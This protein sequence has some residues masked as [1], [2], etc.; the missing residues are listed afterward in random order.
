MIL[1]YCIARSSKDYLQPPNPAKAT[2][3]LGQKLPDAMPALNDR[4]QPEA[5]TAAG[6][7]SN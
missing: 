3:A 4:N 2:A 7:M 1:A 6:R 5:G